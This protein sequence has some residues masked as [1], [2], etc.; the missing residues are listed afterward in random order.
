MADSTRLLIGWREWIALPD[1]KIPVI[2]AK[3]DT[4]ART[5]SLH[6][7]EIATFYRRG[8]L[9]VSFRVHPIQGRRDIIVSC[10]APVIDRRVVS[11]SG[12]HRERRFVIET[13]MSIGELIFPMEVTLANRETMT[14]RMLIGRSAMKNLIID[15]SLSYLLGQPEQRV[16]A[17][18]T[19]KLKRS[20]KST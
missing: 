3:M 7:F 12:G 13:R 18:R 10:E 6:A 16:G 20:G 19:R 1:L 11:D 2:K 5:S 15:P 8:T 4:G 17:Y 14:H 9:Y